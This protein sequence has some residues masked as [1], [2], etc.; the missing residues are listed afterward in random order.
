MHITAE[1]FVGK[2]N[3]KTALRGLSPRW[4]QEPPGDAFGGVL[5]HGLKVNKVLTQGIFQ[6]FYQNNL[7][8]F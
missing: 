2:P 4:P 8:S 3:V 5:P 1:C 6:G 7:D